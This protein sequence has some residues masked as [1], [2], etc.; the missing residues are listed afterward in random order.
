MVVDPLNRHVRVYTRGP[1]GYKYE[2]HCR[3]MGANYVI[4]LDT[5]SGKLVLLPFSN[6]TDVELQPEPARTE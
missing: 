5:K 6:I 3:G 1:P 4:V 2:G